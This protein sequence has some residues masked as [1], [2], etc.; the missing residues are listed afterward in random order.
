M[1]DPTNTI[2]ERTRVDS[3]PQKRVLRIAVTH[4][5]RGG[6]RG[7]PALVCVV[8]VRVAPVRDAPVPV[9]A[10]R[11]T[12]VRDTPLRD[13]PVRGAPDLP[14][15]DCPPLRGG[16]GRF[17]VSSTFGSLGSTVPGLHPAR[18]AVSR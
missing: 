17:D 13:A 5:F 8:A 11:G 6:L 7:A 18:G 14:D 1:T 9:V 3:S 12:P 10:V 2:V 4:H 15:T 16:V